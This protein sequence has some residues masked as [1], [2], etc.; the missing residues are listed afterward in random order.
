MERNKFISGYWLTLAV[1]VVFAAAIFLT[2]PTATKAA[3]NFTGFGFV[4]GN[5]TFT[6]VPVPTNSGSV[7]PVDGFVDQYV[8]A[9]GDDPDELREELL[10]A[11]KDGEDLQVAYNHFVNDDDDD[12]DDGDDDDDDDDDD[13]HGDDEGDDGDDD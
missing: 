11:R 8:N 13:D 9:G 12:D 5:V 1:A 7:D 10:E 4:S 6:D 3:S 2:V